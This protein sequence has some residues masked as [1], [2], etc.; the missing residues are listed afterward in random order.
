MT[1]DLIPD[2]GIVSLSV[3]GTGGLRTMLELAAGTPS[4]GCFV[5]FGVYRGGSAWHL[6]RLAGAQGRAL[7]LFDTF[8]GIP[9]RSVHD[10]QHAVGDFGDADLTTVRSLIPSA[11]FH[12]G[13]FPATM[14]DIGPIAFV[15][16]DCDQYRSCLAAIEQFWPRLISGGLLL[17]D[18]YGATSG[19]TKAVD[20]V[21]ADRIRFR[22]E[23][24]YVAKD[25]FGAVN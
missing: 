10:Q 25:A 16:I 6:A 13:V 20:G 5:E 7:H 23:K 12:V 18:D 15:H 4:A 22:H 9:E 11:I 17:F 1:D 3:I 2:P 19:V 24:A 8:A 21:F 14:T